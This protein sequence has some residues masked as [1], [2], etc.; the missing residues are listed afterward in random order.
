[1]MP[2]L[3][4]E[5]QLSRIEAAGVPHMDKQSRDNVFRRLRGALGRSARPKPATA[6]DLAMLGIHVEQ[7]DS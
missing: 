6:A 3:N 4:A 2:T 1:M 5:Q 7:P